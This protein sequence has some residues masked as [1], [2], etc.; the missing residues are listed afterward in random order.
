MF[1]ADGL[2]QDIVERYASERRGGPV[3]GFAELIRRGASAEAAACS[4]RR[5]PT[6]APAGTMAT[7]A[8]P[9]V[10]G[11]TNNTFHTN[12]DLSPIGLPRSTRA[13]CPAE[14]IAQSAERGGKKVVQMERPAAATAAS[15]ARPLTSG[16]SHGSRRHDQLRV[17][18]TGGVDH[19]VRPAVRPGDAGAGDRLDGSSRSVACTLPA[20][21]ETRMRVLDFGVD[22]YGLD[23]Y[24]YDS[25]DDGERTTTG[26]SSRATRTR[27]T[28]LPIWPKAR[29]PTSR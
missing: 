10:H 17:P 2:R 28:L 25:T 3:P 15:T 26:C 6:P 16:P 29:W 27:R 19:R 20:A 24:I 12:N 23:A 1:A 21:L 14:T 11:S 7:G 9:G 18:T 4:P 5:L 22:K 8:W 13:C